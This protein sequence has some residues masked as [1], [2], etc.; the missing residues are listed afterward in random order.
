MER[1]T[2]VL[3]IGDA[4]IDLVSIP[5]L[6]L[7]II[8]DVNNLGADWIQVLYGTQNHIF[9]TKTLLGADD[10]R[11][12]PVCR[13]LAEKLIKNKCFTDQTSGADQ[14]ICLTFNISLKKVDTND[15]DVVR[16]IAESL[17]TV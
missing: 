12:A 17:V 11:L 5:G 3:A 7:F 14:H 1:K 10:N 8:T 6:N 16:Q 13:Y 9:S 4:T 15:V 2:K